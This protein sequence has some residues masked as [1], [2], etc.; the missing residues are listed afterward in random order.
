MFLP[1]GRNLMLA[2]CIALPLTASLVCPCQLGE[3]SGAAVVAFEENDNTENK[4]CRLCQPGS[5]AGPVSRSLLEQ[6]I[7]PAA[8]HTAT[9]LLVSSSIIARSVTALALADLPLLDLMEIQ[10]LLE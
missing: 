8:N 5:D 3:R 6:D 2:I 10:V 4:E 9:R 1:C 7:R